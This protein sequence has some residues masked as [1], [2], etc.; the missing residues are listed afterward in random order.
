MKKNN[1]LVMISIL[2]AI[3][4]TASS[5]QAIGDIFKAGFWS[6]IIVVVIIVALIL[7]LVGRSRKS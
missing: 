1:H 5:C 4:T 7:W 2:I 6:A 3:V